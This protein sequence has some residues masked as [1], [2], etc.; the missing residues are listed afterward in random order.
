MSNTLMSLD[1][2]GKNSRRHSRTQ[3]PL[4]GRPADGIRS[5]TAVS[6]LLGRERLSARANARAPSTE[7]RQTNPSLLRLRPQ[8]NVHTLDRGR[9]AGDDRFYDVYV[10]IADD[11]YDEHLKEL[12]EGL[13]E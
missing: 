6:L 13:I 11:L 3:W 7:R 1:S 4:G 5:Q 10:P 8:A 12:E 2:G 9:Q